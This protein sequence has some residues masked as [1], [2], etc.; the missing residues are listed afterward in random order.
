M[1]WR[2]SYHVDFFFLFRSYIVQKIHLFHFRNV[3]LNIES[4]NVLTQCFQIRNPSPVPRTWF[5]N[6]II[7]VN[8]ELLTYRHNAFRY[9]RCCRVIFLEGFVFHFGRWF[10]IKRHIRHFCCKFFWN[11]WFHISSPI[12][13]F[14]SNKRVH[15]YAAC[16]SNPPLKPLECNNIFFVSS[17]LVCFFIVLLSPVPLFI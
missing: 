15:I 7:F 16:A 12:H 10:R 2:I 9:P 14:H 17:F 11:I 1:K 4:F 8:I 6:N 3:G 13:C 5:N